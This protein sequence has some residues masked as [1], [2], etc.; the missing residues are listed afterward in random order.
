MNSNP[1]GIANLWLDG[2]MV[3]RTVAVILILVSIAS[4]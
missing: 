1:Y 4:G 3:I 2:D